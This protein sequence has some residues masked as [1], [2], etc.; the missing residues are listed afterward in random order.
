MEALDLVRT[1]E[2]GVWMARIEFDLGRLRLLEG[3]SDLARGHLARAEEIAT[4]LQA[5]AMLT[6]IEQALAE[7][8]GERTVQ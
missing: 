8:R 5:R 7:C 6:R 2:R 4:P 3:R 1:S